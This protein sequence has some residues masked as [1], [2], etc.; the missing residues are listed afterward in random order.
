VIR[1]NNCLLDHNVECRRGARDF[2][3]PPKLPL[4]PFPYQ[5]GFDVAPLR[6]FLLMKP[7]PP[8]EARAPSLTPNVR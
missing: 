3:R 2:G 7:A 8:D 6:D 4:C 5:A 1:Y